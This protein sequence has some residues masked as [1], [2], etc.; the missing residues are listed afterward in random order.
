MELLSFGVEVKV[1]ESE[2]L[3]EEMIEKLEAALLR[4]R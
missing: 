3:K 1:L 2:S 4:Y